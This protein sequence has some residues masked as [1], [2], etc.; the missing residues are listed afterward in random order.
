MANPLAAFGNMILGGG[1]NAAQVANSVFEAVL[2]D[3]PQAVDRQL[4]KTGDLNTKDQVRGPWK[5]GSL[6]HV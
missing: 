4:S 1:N 6:K 3:D 5:C 2:N